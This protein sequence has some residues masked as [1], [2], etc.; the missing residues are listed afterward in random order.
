MS[1]F[2]LRTPLGRL[3]LMAWLEGISFLVLL[4]ITMPLKYMMG[5]KEPNHVVGMVHGALF[6]F[7]TLFLI[8][9][10]EEYNWKRSVF[11]KGFIAAWFPF[12]TFWADRK[13]FTIPNS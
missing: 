1:D 13:L 3:K 2:S 4:F 7:Y 6:V 11:I 8:L 12:A 5:I 9:A 10:V